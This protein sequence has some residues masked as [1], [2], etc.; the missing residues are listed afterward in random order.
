LTDATL[1]ARS[2]LWEWATVG[3]DD[4]PEQHALKALYAECL[5]DA[6]EHVGLLAADEVVQWRRL[7]SHGRPPP[8]A[9]GDLDGAERHLEELLA[10]VPPMAR[11]PQAAAL[12]ATRRFDAALAA[13][14]ASGVLSDEAERRWRS[15]GLAAEAPWLDDDEISEIGGMEGIYAI[16]IPPASP[17][18]EAADAAAMQEME[19]AGRRGRAKRVFVPDRLQRHDGLAI[20]GVIMRAEATEVVFH[21]VGDA[22]GDLTSGSAGL[23]AFRTTID[24]LVPPRLED[25]TGI[26]YEP[27]GDRPVSSHGSGGT[28]DPVRPRVITGAWRYQPPAPDSASAFEVSAADARWRLTFR[29]A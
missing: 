23:E 8:A 4:D 22:Y 29:R 10:A 21:H 25:D 11:E 15:R 2:L 5:V 12:S 20:V 3:Q 16:R 27:L 28:P 1:E 7:L 13:L 19:T 18:E 9:P 26:V 24:A 17:E 6:C 14:H